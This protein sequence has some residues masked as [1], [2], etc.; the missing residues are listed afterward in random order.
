MELGGVGVVIKY[1]SFFITPTS[2]PFGATPPQ[3]ENF[4]LWNTNLLHQAKAKPWRSLGT[5]QAMTDNYYYRHIF[6]SVN[7]VFIFIFFS[8]NTVLLPFSVV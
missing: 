4:A 3:E 2:S 7:K 5:T 8:K 6:L 1:I